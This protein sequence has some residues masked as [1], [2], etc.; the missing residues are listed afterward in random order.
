MPSEILP[1]KGTK[2]GAAV[3]CLTPMGFRAGLSE[4]NVLVAE[5]G[6][7]KDGLPSV[8]SLLEQPLWVCLCRYR[9]NH[10]TSRRHNYRG[11]PQHAVERLA[12]MRPCQG[13][14]A[15]WFTSIDIEI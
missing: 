4:N 10:R 14:A 12:R 5:P 3:S 2:Q 8:A 7:F 11:R 13:F 6:L 15:T 1:L 9:T